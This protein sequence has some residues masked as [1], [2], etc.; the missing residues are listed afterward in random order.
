MRRKIIFLSETYGG[1]V[2]D[3]KIADEHPLEFDK[4]ITLLQDSGFIG[5]NP[6]NAKVKQPYKNSKLKKLTEEQKIENKKQAS[7][8]VR[9]E[10]SISGVKR[11]RIVKDIFRN[12]RTGMIDLS[13]QIACGLHNLRIAA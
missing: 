8:R 4:E 3:K 11:V 2:H 12:R 5:H 9:V 1:K 10:H 6:K 13:M 7:K